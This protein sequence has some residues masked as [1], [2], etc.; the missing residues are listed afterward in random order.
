M[1]SLIGY[2]TSGTSKV[3]T[4][5]YWVCDSLIG[6]WSVVSPERRYL[7]N[8]SYN[9]GFNGTGYT[10]ILKPSRRKLL[11]NH[12]YNCIIFYLFLLNYKAFHHLY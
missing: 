9:C 5:S 4:F 6:R 10:V 8:Y 11:L 7:A 2:N 1:V 12:F 3:L